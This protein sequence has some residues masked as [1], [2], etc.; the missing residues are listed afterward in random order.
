MKILLILIIIF[1]IIF[2]IINNILKK[3]TNEHYLTY[4]LPFYDSS[5][6]DLSN[7]Y[8]YNENNDNYFKKKFNYTVLKFGTTIIEKF[9]FENLISYYISYSNLINAN[10][11]L[12]KDDIKNLSDLVNNKINFSTTT[13]STI[14]YYKDILKQDINNIRLIKTLYKIY[15]YIFT[16]KIYNVF[17]I[18]D[19]RPGFIIGIIGG[20]NSFSLYYNLFFRDLGFIENTDYIIKKYDNINKL[21][22]G[23]VKSECNMIIINDIFPNN[24]IINFLD[25]IKDEDII[26][27]PFNIKNE[28]L[29]LKKQEIINID[30]IDLNQ[31]S[32]SYLPRK[33]GKNE[34]TKNKPTLKICY[35]NKILISNISTDPLYT[36][37]YIKFYHENYKSINNNLKE[38]GYKIKN[39]TI[40]N[41]KTIYIDYHIGVLNFFR[42]KG[43]ITNNK[44]I[45]C[46]YLVNTIECTDKTLL[47]NNLVNRF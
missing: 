7:F 1:S 17:Q 44:N 45:N 32:S 41:Y 3:I 29:F 46:K 36:Y 20:Y 4:F 24:N 14:K 34:Y 28:D 26:L 47:D 21:F 10:I 16:K 40:S 27:L 43:Y 25:N 9:F 8:K 35:L 38:I 15:I 23:F 39:I 19:I 37:E 6:I 31:L 42:D 22:E 2:Y 12:Y 5:N 30:Y 18:N 13:Y 33:F 11:I